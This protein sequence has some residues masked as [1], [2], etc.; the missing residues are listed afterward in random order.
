MDKGLGLIGLR[1]LGLELV[2]GDLTSR[3]LFSVFERLVVFVGAGVNALLFGNVFFAGCTK[4]EGGSVG[5]EGIVEDGHRD[6]RR[7][8]ALPLL[9]GITGHGRSQQS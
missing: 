3:P 8:L 7:G 6:G 1:P 5:F 9:I 4:R 2:V